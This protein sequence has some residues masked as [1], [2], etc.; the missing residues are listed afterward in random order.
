MDLKKTINDTECDLAVIGTPIDLWSII[1]IKH[2]AV[3]VGKLLNEHHHYLDKY[4]DISTEKI[5][6]LLGE[7]SHLRW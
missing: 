7:R 6:K 1:V 3:Q 5:N 4:L 2:P